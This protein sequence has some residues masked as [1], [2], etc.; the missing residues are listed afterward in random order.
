M[1]NIIAPMVPSS[2]PPID[3]AMDDDDDDDDEFGDFAAAVD[4]T[5][6]GAGD[7]FI[8]VLSLCL[9]NGG[10]LLPAHQHKQALSWATL[11]HLALS[12]LWNVVQ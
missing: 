4:L 3:D 6:S 11:M 10:Q 5:C 12:L 8:T 1:S 2:P 7:C 9:A